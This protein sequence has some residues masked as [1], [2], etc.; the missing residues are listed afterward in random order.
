MDEDEVP[1]EGRILYI[2]PALLKAVKKL[3]TTKSREI[4]E[5][6]EK[7]VKVPQRR[8]YTA[9]ELLDGQSEGEEAGGYKMAAD[10]KEINF[11]IVH[12]SAVVKIDKHVVKDI[13]LPENNPNADATIVK[14]RKYG[15]VKVQ[16]NKA[17]GIY[18]SHKE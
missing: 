5:E 14:Y 6:F 10:G 8:F 18:I 4:L 9:I 2:T 7:V 17:A 3:D 16:K 11:T 12:K 15:T 13:I 1:A